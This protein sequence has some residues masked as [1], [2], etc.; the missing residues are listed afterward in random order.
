MTTSKIAKWLPWVIIL[1]GFFLRLDQYIFNRSLWLDEAFLASSIANGSVIDFFRPLEYTNVVPTGFSFMIKWCTLQFGN[2]DVILRLFPFMVGIASLF[3]FHKVAET[4]VSQNAALIS[5]FLFAISD[6][7]IYYS[8]DLKPYSTD[9]AVTL[10]I[11][12]VAAHSRKR[13][14]AMPNIFLLGFTG[15]V[16]IWFS[17]ASIFVLAG[18]GAYLA[19]PTILNKEW[20]RAERYAFAFLAWGVSFIAF[21]F[22]FI[23]N[24]N[25]P[26]L[27]KFWD[28]KQAFMPS[29]F[30][31]SCIKWFINTF[32]AVFKNPGGFTQNRIAA[33]AGM[34]FIYGC[35]TIYRNQRGKLCIL[36]FPIIIAVIA[37]AFKRYL[38]YE[39]MILFFLPSLFL[40][41]A[42]GIASISF[43]N[44]FL[45][46]TVS[47]LLIITLCYYPSHSAIS[48][49]RHER[50]VEEIKPVLKYIKG[51]MRPDDLLY[52]Y[53]WAEPA[54]RYYADLYSFD[55]NK[56]VII[57]PEPVNE[58][59]KEVDYYRKSPKNKT[60]RIFGSDYDT[61]CIKCVMGISE[62]FSKCRDEIDR[63]RGNNRVWFVFTHADT[64]NFLNYLDEIGTRLDAN[65]QPGA[66]CY[67]YHL[68]NRY[69]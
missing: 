20:E 45:K 58:Y 43:K 53:Y 15:A 12:L 30:S 27:F 18:V 11:F 3:L 52:I 37:S 54:F 4:Y 41:I 60:A 32:I 56:C 64:N 44:I 19:L 25:N 40:V 57:S 9:V 46:H 50:V 66:A 5:L 29:I 21:Y 26:W 67:L 39:R 8:S 51:H 49:L 35:V 65:L 63:I 22:V 17:H 68:D 42:E 1:L 55:Y 48:H 62:E 7:L 13:N 14:L 2:N 31:A 36:V 33:A 23:R 6:R 69:K 28:L 38:I 59:I 47:I 16:S 10:V 34:I 61:N 24:Y